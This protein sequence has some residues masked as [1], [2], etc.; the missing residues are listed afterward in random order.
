M[1]LLCIDMISLRFILIEILESLCFKRLLGAQL[2]RLLTR[3][4]MQSEKA[5]IPP[6]ES[7]DIPVL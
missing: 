3:S 4:M 7:E 5:L 2:S 6:I 1:N